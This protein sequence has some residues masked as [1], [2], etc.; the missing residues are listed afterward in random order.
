[1]T[2][3]R[4]EAFQPLDE[5]CATVEQLIAATKSARKAPGV[6]EIYAPG[7]PEWQKRESYLRYG[8][9]LPET[10]WQRIV[11]AGRQYDVDVGE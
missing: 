6:D 10:T 4:I 3:I 9:E 11:E 5:F 1:M 8:L 2:A 7:E